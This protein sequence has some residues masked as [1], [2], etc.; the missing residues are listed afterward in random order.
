MKAFI[1][2]LISVFTSL[3][4]ANTI[5]IIEDGI[6]VIKGGKNLSKVDD[7]NLITKAGKLS[8]ITIKSLT[9]TKIENLQNLMALAVKENRVGFVKQFKYIQKYKSMKEGDKILLKC[10]NDSNCNLA[11]Y[12]DLISKSPLHRQ[13]AMKYSNMSLTQINHK[14]GTLNENIMNKYFQS[15]GWT[16]LEGEVGRNGI[17]GLFVKRKNGIIIDVL[18]VESKYNKSGLQYTKNGQQ[19]T[20]QWLTKKIKDLKKKYPNDKNYEAIE[21]HIDN[22]NYRG[23]L[24]NLKI[25]DDNI[26]ISLKK[27]NDKN[28]KIITSNLKGREKIKINYNGN[29]EININ[30]PQSE[31]HKKLISWYK[32]ELNKY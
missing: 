25:K 29:Q 11:K 10:L 21:K 19:M 22:D 8:K 23:L 13:F 3:T 27:V 17:D 32:G 20:K 28:N 26:I 30:N 5:N 12:T 9:L 14:I 18:I 2:T 7:I 15:T 24:W 6:K 4:Y 31:F 16:K 1:F